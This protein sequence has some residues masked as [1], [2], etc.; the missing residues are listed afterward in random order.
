LRREG[1]GPAPGGLAAG[2]LAFIW[3]VDTN[4]NPSTGQLHFFVGSEF[5]LRVANYGQGWIGLIDVISGPPVGWGSVF[6]DGATVSIAVTRSQ[7]GSPTAFNWEICTL[8]G[9]PGDS[10]DQFATEN[11]VADPPPLGG[12]GRVRI[13]PVTLALFGHPPKSYVQALA[14]DEAGAPVSLRGRQ[15][16]FFSTDATVAAVNEQGVVEGK[17]GAGT[18]QVTARVENGADVAT[19]VYYVLKR[20]NLHLSLPDTPTG[21]LLVFDST[22][23]RITEGL[24]F[25][26]FDGHTDSIGSKAYNQELSQRR[27]GARWVAAHRA[28][29][30]DCCGI[31]FPSPAPCRNPTEYVGG[32]CCPRN[33][34]Y[35]LPFAGVQPGPCT[36]RPGVTPVC[37]PLARTWTPLTNTSTTPVAYW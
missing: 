1:D 17:G 31:V 2:A 29:D 28:N 14:S 26:G 10:A 4:Q 5:N 12:V 3:L 25:S 35:D 30:H 8:G 13:D 23:T 22:G 16:L 34:P 24:E 9:S 7:L 20:Y 33:R 6:I 36:K 27:A 11:I 37:S 18:V 15:V 21:Q 19:T 32:T